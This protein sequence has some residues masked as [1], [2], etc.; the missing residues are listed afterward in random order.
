VQ[1]NLERRRTNK[2]RAI[3]TRDMCDLFYR[4]S[5]LENLIPIEESTKDE[6]FSTLSL[7]PPITKTSEL[8]F[9]F[10][11]KRPKSPQG[12]PQR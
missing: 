10:V 2:S 7:S 5:V 6:P 3:S 11:N 12:Q 4:G 9:F 1:E 8:F